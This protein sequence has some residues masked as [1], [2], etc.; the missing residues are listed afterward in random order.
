MLKL[1]TLAPDG[2][3]KKDS[4]KTIPL[5]IYYVILVRSFEDEELPFFQHFRSFKTL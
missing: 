4:V 5:L 1:K 3:M 2:V